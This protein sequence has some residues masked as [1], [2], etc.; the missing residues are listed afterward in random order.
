MEKLE[1]VKYISSQ[2]QSWE[3]EKLIGRNTSGTFDL[4]ITQY[5]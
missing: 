4:K 1:C 5:S 3:A 2:V